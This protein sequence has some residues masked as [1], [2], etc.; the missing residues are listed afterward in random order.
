MCD[1]PGHSA[2]ADPNSDAG[3]DADP[4]ATA[5]PTPA[6]VACVPTPAGMVSWWPGDGNP[7]DIVEGNNGILAGGA[8][9]FTPGEVGPAFDFPNS[10]TGALKY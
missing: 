8:T 1:H 9:I 4:D 7:N 2:D 6:A 5:T 3:A 10:S